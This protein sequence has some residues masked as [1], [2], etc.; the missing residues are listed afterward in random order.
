[1]DQRGEKRGGTND[2]IL[3]GGELISA[4]PLFRQAAVKR[5]VSGEV[6][7]GQRAAQPRFQPF[8]P[9]FRH[10]R[11]FPQPHD[12]PL[13]L[14]LMCAESLVTFLQDCKRNCPLLKVVTGR[15][16]MFARD[17]RAQIRV[18]T[19][20]QDKMQIMGFPVVIRAIRQI[21]VIQRHDERHAAV[22][23]FH[24]G[25]DD[26]PRPAP[27]HRHADQSGK[28]PLIQDIP[29]DKAE[30]RQ[31]VGGDDFHRIV[32]DDRLG[33]NPVIA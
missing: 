18:V 23:A 10:G 20:Y 27:F 28:I 11:I 3:K 33:R 4:V 30:I 26:V 7:P 24:R 22:Y 21:K 5:A 16:F 25:A 6:S 29:L 8:P 13:K 1:M 12:A 32:A 14:R 9:P 19:V 31:A 15:I 2:R 17:Q